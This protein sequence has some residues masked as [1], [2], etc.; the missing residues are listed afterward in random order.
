MKTILR[1]RSVGT[2]LA[3]H[4]AVVCC[5]GSFRMFVSPSDSKRGC[6][7]VR[8]GTHNIVFSLVLSGPCHSNKG[9]VIR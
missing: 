6:F 5:S 4:S 1:R 3:R 2:H 8:A 7:R 9:F